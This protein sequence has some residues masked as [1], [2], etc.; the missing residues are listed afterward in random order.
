MKTLCKSQEL[1]YSDRLR[2]D[3]EKWCRKCHA[4]EARKGTETRTKGPLQRYNM[5]A[6]FERMTLDILGSFPVTTKCNRERM[7]TRY[8][9]GATDHHFKDGVKGWMYNPKRRMV[10]SPKPQQNWEGPYTIVKKLNDV[11][12]RVQRSPNAKPKVIHIN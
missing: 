11:I 7:K 10:L 4:C 8:E 3:I 2:A 9:S 12:Y 5:G 1:F 6:P